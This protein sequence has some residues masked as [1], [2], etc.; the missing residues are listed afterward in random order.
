MCPLRER[1]PK[2]KGKMQVFQDKLKFVREQ[3]IDIVKKSETADIYAFKCTTK[4]AWC[5]KPENKGKDPE[6]EGHLVIPATRDGHL[7]D[8]VWMRKGHKDEWDAE[9]KESHAVE[10][11]TRVVDDKSVLRDGQLDKQFK[12]AADKISANKNKKMKSIQEDDEER[13]QKLM[14]QEEEQDREEEAREK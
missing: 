13:L 10:K 11:R 2:S 14:H 9:I 12:A 8:V 1:T 7:V 4:D 6:A 3:V 5:K